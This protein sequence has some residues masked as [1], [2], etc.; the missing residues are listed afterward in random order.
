MT[1]VSHDD[2]ECLRSQ[3]EDRMSSSMREVDKVFTTKI[4]TKC[5]KEK[6]KDSYKNKHYKTVAQINKTV[7]LENSCPSSLA[8]SDEKAEFSP[9]ATKKLRSSPRLK[10]LDQTPTST[11]DREHLSIRQAST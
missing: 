3:R 1:C 11:W 2:K 4:R 5:T 9:P 7:I 8:P 10:P 6:N